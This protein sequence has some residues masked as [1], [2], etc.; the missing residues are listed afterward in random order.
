M[1][2]K[3]VETLQA[4]AGWRMFSFLKIITDDGL[5]VSVPNATIFTGTKA[6]GNG[7]AGVA[8]NGGATNNTIGG[9]TAGSGNVISS[10][11][12]DGLDDINANSNLIVGNCHAGPD[13]PQLFAKRGNVMPE[14]DEIRLASIPEAP[15]TITH[16]RMRPRSYGTPVIVLPATCGAR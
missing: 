11:A 9:T 6:M 12:G 8:I 5:Y 10:S 14:H 3:A 16:P 15:T 2:I 4:D 1:K 13:N 7:Q